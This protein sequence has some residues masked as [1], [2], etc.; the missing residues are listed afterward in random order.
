MS[1]R[2][3]YILSVCGRVCK[4][5]HEHTSTRAHEH[6]KEPPRGHTIKVVV[7]KIERT[8]LHLAGSHSEISR[9]FAL[10]PNARIISNLEL[11]EWRTLGSAMQCHRWIPMNQMKPKTSKVDGT[12][13]C[14]GRRF[15]TGRIP[16]NEA[17]MATTRQSAYC[18]NIS[19]RNIASREI[20]KDGPNSEWAGPMVFDMSD[21]TAGMI[22]MC[23]LLHDSESRARP[24]SLIGDDK[25]NK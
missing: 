21:Q 25:W 24:W 1:S 2:K 9:L 22:F 11:I 12:A 10:G 15:Y 8:N 3:W 16:R 14:N 4:S 18:G 17:Q 13:I 7:E 5:L 6:L 20:P 19:S 23:F